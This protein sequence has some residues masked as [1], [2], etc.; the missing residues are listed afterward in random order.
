[1]PGMR[2]D[3]ILIDSNPM[4]ATPEAIRAT[5]V[6]ETWINGRAVWVR[7]FA[8]TVPAHTP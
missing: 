1:M 8:S 3:F 6:R 4:G 2:A 5:Q 7:G